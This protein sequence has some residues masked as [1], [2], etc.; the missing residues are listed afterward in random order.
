MEIAKEIASRVADALLSDNRSGDDCIL[1]DKG[2]VVIT[3]E[4]MHRIESTITAKLEPIRRTIEYVL[5][6]EEW[7]MG[8]V[9]IDCLEEII[10]MLSEE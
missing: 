4:G 1:I 2:G 9:G 7:Q 10:E 3:V 8:K 5:S 6:E